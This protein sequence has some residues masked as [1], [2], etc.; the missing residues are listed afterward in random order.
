MRAGRHFVDPIGLAHQTISQTERL[1]HL[2]GAAGDSVGLAHLEWTVLALD[3]R[4]PDLGELGHLRSQDQPR[5]TRS[6]DQDVD[7]LREASGPLRDDRMRV[8]D[9]RV[10]GCVSV[11]IELH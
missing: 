7:V 1:E 6:N 5:R 2:H 4:R 10:S 9:E 8:L 3:D 11:E